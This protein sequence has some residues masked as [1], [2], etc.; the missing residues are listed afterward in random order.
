MFP[1]LGLQADWPPQNETKLLEIPYYNL[2][3][4]DKTLDME[5]LKMICDVQYAHLLSN[6]VPKSLKNTETREAHD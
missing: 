6:Y 5:L 1:T 4:G 2:V 3:E